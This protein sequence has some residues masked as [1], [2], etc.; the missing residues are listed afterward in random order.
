MASHQSGDNLSTGMK[1]KL[2]SLEGIV[3]TIQDD[4][5]EHVKEMGK[6][7]NEEHTLQ[8]ILDKSMGEVK[9]SIEGEI[10]HIEGNMKQHFT[11]LKVTSH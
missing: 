4:L 3:Q 8:L 5:Q 10:N 1:T 7:K 9:T 11:D 6:L 2:M